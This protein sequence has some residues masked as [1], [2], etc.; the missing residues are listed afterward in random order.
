MFVWI[1]KVHKRRFILA[2]MN[3]GV[4]SLKENKEINHKTKSGNA[5]R[6]SNLLG[7]LL[8]AH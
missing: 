8:L 7:S 3:E 2:A 1:P 6:L 5:S 4:S